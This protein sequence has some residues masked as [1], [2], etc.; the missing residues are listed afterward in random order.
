MLPAISEVVLVKETLA[1]PQSEISQEHAARVN[2]AFH[3]VRTSVDDEAMQMFAAPTQ[4]CLQ[5]G[6]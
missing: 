6:V 4:R 2:E 5:G 3:A 1:Y